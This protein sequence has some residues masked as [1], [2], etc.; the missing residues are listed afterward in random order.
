MLNR[1]KLKD[2]A[3]IRI[4]EANILL[5]NNNFDGAYYLAGYSIECALKA[6]I[7]K[8]V[9]KYDFPDLSTVKQ[10]Y[11]HNLTDLFKTAGLWVQFQADMSTN[12]NLQLNWTIVK[13]WSEVSRYE[14]HT[15]SPAE[16]LIHAIMDQNEGVLEWIKQHW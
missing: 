6:G 3:L 4:S 1:Q 12:S 15:K 8:Q 13:D 10:S 11:T 2:L 5:Q 7:A 14:K 9:Q 16:D